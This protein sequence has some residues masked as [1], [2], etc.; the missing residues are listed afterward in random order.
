MCSLES[1]SILCELYFD[2]SVTRG[3]GNWQEVVNINSSC[4][5]LTPVI[6]SHLPYPGSDMLAIIREDST[7]GGARQL[8]S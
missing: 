5:N 8:A 2:V 3:V 7:S 4:T 6:G 1:G